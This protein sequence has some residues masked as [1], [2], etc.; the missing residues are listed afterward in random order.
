[1]G[2][3]SSIQ[4]AGV[5]WIYQSA[6]QA[7]L[8]D[9]NR[10]FIS[11]EMGFLMRWLDTQPPDMVAAVAQLVAEDRLQLVNSGWS[12]GDEACVSYADAVDQMSLGA[13]LANQSFGVL[14]ASRC[15]WSIDPFGHSA[16]EGVL[17]AQMGHSGFFYGRL[18]WQEQ[19]A[20][21]AG[22]ATEYVWRPSLS[23]GAAAQVFAGSNVH[24][25]D[26]PVLTD[27]AHPVFEWDVVSDNPSRPALLYGPFQPFPD[28][29][30]YNLPQY[31]SATLALAQRQ[32]A[33]TLPDEVDG[34][35]HIAWQFGTDFNYAAAEMWFTQID[36]LMSAV[37][38]NQT[39]IHLLYSTPRMYMDAKLAQ[40]T[41]WPIKP[42]TTPDGLSTDQLPY[43]TN[44]HWVWSGFFSSRP[45]LKGY[46][47]LCSALHTAARQLQVFTGGAPVD[48]LG[49]ANPLFALERSLATAQHHDAVTGTARQH[50]TYDYAK[51]LSAGVADASALLTA[52]LAQL[53]RYATGNFTLCLLSNA[54]IA[55]PTL[56]APA[57]SDPPTLVLLYNSGSLP[58][59]S[60]P[61][62]LPVGL[63]PGIAS[64][65]VA[66]PDGASAVT[67]QL[68]PPSPADLA[69][70]TGYYRAPERP[71]SWLAWQAPSV[72]ALGFA[73]FFLSPAATPQLAP[74]THASARLRLPSGSADTQLSNGVLTLTFDGSSGLVSGL[75]DAASGI[76]LPLAQRLFYY[77]A[78]AGCPLPPLPCNIAND[79]T[80][81]SA[82]GQSATTYI[83]RPNSSTP[84]PLA[85]GGEPVD[86]EVLRGPVLSEARQ[87]WA[88]GAASM[89]LR[90]WANA[91][92]VEAEWTAGPLPLGDGWGK[93]L[94][95]G[96]DLGGGWGAGQPATLYHDSQ[97]RELQK[98][99]LNARSFPSNVSLY[100]PIAANLYPVTARA[101]LVDGATGRRFTLAV[102]RAQ[103]CASLAPGRLECLLHRRHLASTFLGMGEVLNETGLDAGGSGLVVRGVHWLRLDA[104][105][106][107]SSAV[108][109]VLAAAALPLTVLTAPLPRA[110]PPPAQWAANHTTLWSALA[111]PS[112]LRLP[113]QISLQTLQSLGGS[114]LLLRL[115]HTLAVGEDA[116][117]SSNATVSMAALFSP[118][119]LQVVG[120]EEMSLGGVVPLT[121]VKPWT[122]RVQGE[123]NAVTL[124]IVPPAPCA[125]DFSA[126]LAPMQVRTFVLQVQG[127]AY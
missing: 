118:A 14:A 122:L 47:R 59:A 69:L 5:R 79:G 25:Y 68:L 101:V 24:G 44:P 34:T 22:N 119:V 115:A 73:A 64:W 36:G 93:E 87:A 75:A 125:P 83:F 105:G 96:W 31:V 62:R 70:R 103:G 71:M 77:R 72:P 41:S 121:Q 15:A 23:L 98:R 26:P 95:A 90:L 60:A 104:P 85:P 16:T 117:L 92:S 20:Q 21:V 66:G 29:G 94:M 3:N 30:G 32:A 99:V 37:N 27:S 61:V 120:V 88:G 76:A 82:Y 65:A 10:R 51:S 9:P 74:S 86:L 81:L 112:A 17:S 53:T 2:L 102:D 57:P 123:A 89:V 67:A 35:Q 52:A 63:P 109:G 56:E 107:S 19:A 127:G 4:Q 91:S 126:T 39:A 12:M 108:A 50:T 28:I 43:A 124:P 42:A 8:R 18:D 114:R 48:A 54:T 110:A 6:V 113:P 11:V 97:G 106:A 33:Y 38:A 78:S 7:L 13:R 49:P 111:A 46:I 100:E 58:R 55:C 116:A 45:A 84:A 40:R 1:M 80:G